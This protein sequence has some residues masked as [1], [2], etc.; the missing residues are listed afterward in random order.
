MDEVVTPIR[1]ARLEMIPSAGHNLSNEQPAAVS[2]AIER[3]RRSQS[4]AVLA[5]GGRTAGRRSQL[6]GA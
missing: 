5:R 6:V 4:A 3:F 2:A 1:H